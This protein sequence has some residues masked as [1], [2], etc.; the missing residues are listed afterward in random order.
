MTITEVMVISGQLRSFNKI[1]VRFCRVQ[2]HTWAICIVD[3]AVSI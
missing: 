2:P 1:A 3:K